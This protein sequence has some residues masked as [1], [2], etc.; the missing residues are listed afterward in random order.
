MNG[1]PEVPVERIAVAVYVIP[2]DA[3]ESD[4]TFEWTST[5]MVLV[6]ASG[7]G[8]Q[9]LGYSYAHHA[10]AQVI[11]D[12]LAP[13][14]QGRDAFAVDG[15]WV[16]MVRAVRNVGL[17]GIAATAIS[18][19]D[20]A[21]WDL[22]ARLLDVPL[23]TLLGSV[24]DGV[25]V[26]GSGGFTSYTERRLREQLAQWVSQGITRVKMKVGRD[27]S[28]DLQRVRAARDAIGPAAELFVDANGGYRRKQALEFAAAYHDL[29][30][31]WFEEPVSSDDLAGLRL[32]R[33]HAP[34]GI[35]I[36]AGEYGFDV[37]YFRR[38]V[39]AGAVDVLQADATRCCGITGFLHAGALCESAMLPLSAHTAPSVH[40]HLGCALPRLRHLEWFHDHVR[41]EQMLFDGWLAPE[42]GVLRPD[43]G[44][45]GL[46]VVLKRADA[47]R[48]AA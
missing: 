1:R 21:L 40:A 47:A 9:G 25:P 46:G 29:D 2:T 32:L 4:G 44:R 15:S 16:A 22:K 12:T 11:T 26:Y 14:V 23:V 7:G 20:S 38:M 5:T 18:A 48:Y 17:Q 41:I 30:V 42:N 39:D 36:A 3:P 10:A 43:R 24:R 28:V 6:T 19:V 45:P 31:S 8:R 13:I 35:E 27:P 37:W 34:P 33:D